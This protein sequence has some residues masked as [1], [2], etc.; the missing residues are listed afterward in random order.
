VNSVAIIA[1]WHKA[2]TAAIT[3]SVVEWLEQRQVSVALGR[4]SAKRLSRPELARDDPD[5]IGGAD[6]VLALGGDGTLL[7]TARLAAPRGVPILGINLGGFGFLTTVGQDEMFQVLPAILAG[8]YQVEERIM[9]AAELLRR[10]Q[11]LESFV[12]LNDVVISKGAFSRLVRLHT[13][14]NGEYLGTFPGDGMIVSTPTG[15]TAYSLSAGGPVINPA[16]QVMVITPICP[17]T[18]SARPLI[19]SADEEVE[20]SVTSEP[21]GRLE[22]VVTVDGQLGYDMQP[23]DLLRVRRADFSAKFV[24]LG[25]PSFYLRLRTKLRWGERRA[26]SGG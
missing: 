16:T 6:L 15:S 25:R 7:G 24:S 26:R 14:V 23:R 20:I 2:H 17:H 5:L 12:A 10:S 11:V 18:L 22:L 13:S 1:A 19:V 3:R 4:E 21:S 8:D 9:L